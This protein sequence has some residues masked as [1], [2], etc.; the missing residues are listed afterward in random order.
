MP[1][2]S[3]RIAGQHLALRGEFEGV[4]DAEGAAVV[5]GGPPGPAFQVGQAH[6]DD[7]LAGQPG[8]I[9]QLAGGEE[10]PAGFLERVVQP[11]RRGPVVRAER[12]VGSLGG[13]WGEDGVPDRLTGRRQVALEQAGAVGQPGQRQ[14]PVG[15]LPALLLRARPV[16]IEVGQDPLTQQLDGA[17]IAGPG[18]LQQRRLDRTGVLGPLGARN[19]LDHLGDLAA[20]SGPIS[21]AANASAV[22]G[23]RGSNGSPVRLRRA[24][25]R[26]TARYR[27]RASP[28]VQRSWVAINCDSPR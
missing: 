7:Q 20:C 10:P 13:E 6:G 2:A 5:G 27:F 1:P 14:P 9:G 11:L 24:P 17:R 8:L 16:R 28:G 23:S 12:I 26:S 21:P 3:A 15:L 22:A 25:N 19:R 18:M 4:V